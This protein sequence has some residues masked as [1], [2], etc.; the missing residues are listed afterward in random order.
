[1]ILHFAVAIDLQLLMSVNKSLTIMFVVYFLHNTIASFLIHV[2]AL[3][4]AVSLNMIRYGGHGHVTGYDLSIIICASHTKSLNFYFFFYLFLEIE[5]LDL[6]A[7]L[8]VYFNRY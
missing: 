4:T 8:T 6:K 7:I 3:K 2:L 5:F 1:M